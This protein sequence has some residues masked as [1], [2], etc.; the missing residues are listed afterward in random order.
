VPDTTASLLTFACLSCVA[1]QVLLPARAGPWAHALAKLGA[2]TFFVLLAVSLGAL[3]S[4]YGQ[5]VLAALLL[6]WVGDALLLSRRT[7]AFLAGLGAFLA[8]HV[9][10]AAAFLLGDTSPVAMAVAFV[11]ALAAGAVVL[12][13][14]RPHVPGDMKAPVIAYVVVILA[15]CI[16]A[17]G[18]AFASGPWTVLAGAV[19]FAASDLAV[20]R[21]RFVAPSRFNAQWGLPLYFAAQLL[22]AST[23][24]AHP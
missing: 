11:V 6:S 14:L 4:R 17:S 22:L 16:A 18:Y 23:V 10:Y 21:E 12:R 3:A 15:M 19:M 9:L 20:A 1:W 13:W 7:P 8:A 24:A 5:F 2:S